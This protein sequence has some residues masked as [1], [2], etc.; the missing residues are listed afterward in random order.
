[1]VLGDYGHLEIFQLINS[2]LEFSGFF[3]TGKNNYPLTLSVSSITE[4]N[5][6]IA[7]AYKSTGSNEIFL[8]IFTWDKVTVVNTSDINLNYCYYDNRIHIDLRSN[9]LLL[10]ELLSS[11]ICIY[12]IGND[13]KQLSQKLD[14]PNAVIWAAFLSNNSIYVNLN[15]G[16][17]W[18][19][20]LNDLNMKY[21]LVS[22]LD[23]LSP[24]AKSSI[25]DSFLWSLLSFSF[26]TNEQFTNIT[27][28]RSE[29]KIENR[30]LS[31]SVW[32]VSMTTNEF[33]STRSRLLTQGS[34]H[35]PSTMI[36][37]PYLFGGHSC[38]VT[39]R[40]N[41]SLYLLLSFPNDWRIQLAQLEI[42]NG[43]IFT[44][45]HS[46]ILNENSF[47]IGSTSLYFFAKG[48]NQL[49]C[50]IRK[51]IDLVSSLWIWDG[52][53]IS[54]CDL[55]MELYI[56][57]LCDNDLVWVITSQSIRTFNKG[58][59]NLLSVISVALSSTASENFSFLSL[60]GKKY[61]QSILLLDQSSKKA[62]IINMDSYIELEWDLNLDLGLYYNFSLPV[63]WPY[64][65]K[66][67]H[68]IGL[69]PSQNH[70]ELFI[71]AQNNI[72]IV[73]YRIEWPDSYKNEYILNSSFTSPLTAISLLSPTTN[74]LI[75]WKFDI[76]T[77]TFTGC[78]IPKTS[79]FIYCY[80]S[81]PVLVSNVYNMTSDMMLLINSIDGPMVETISSKG[82]PIS[83]GDHGAYISRSPMLQVNHIM[84][85]STTTIS[86]DA[87]NIFDIL[88]WQSFF[89]SFAEFLKRLLVPLSKINLKSIPLDLLIIS[90]NHFDLN[91]YTDPNVIIETSSNYD[92][93]FDRDDTNPLLSMN[94]GS[95]DD[96]KEHDDI[97]CNTNF[98]CHTNTV[99]DNFLVWINICKRINIEVVGIDQNGKFYLSWACALCLFDEI[100][101]YPLSGE[102]L[103]IG[104]HSENVDKLLPSLIQLVG[105]KLSW[106]TYVAC[107]FPLL[108][109][110]T[111]DIWRQEAFA[112]GKHFMAMEGNDPSIPLVNLL[113]IAAQKHKLLSSLWR[114]RGGGPFGTK[115]CKLYDSYES[116]HTNDNYET[117]D[118]ID[119]CS[120]SKI[121]EVALKNAFICMS[122][123]EHA[124]A[125]TLFI[126]GNDQRAAI[127]SADRICPLL[128][129]LIS[130]CLGMYKDHHCHLRIEEP[131]ISIDNSVKKF[132]EELD[133]GDVVRP[134]YK[135][136]LLK[137]IANFYGINS[138][139]LLNRWIRPFSSSIRSQVCNYNFNCI[140]GAR[141]RKDISM[142]TY[143]NVYK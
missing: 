86:M 118:S 34:V 16:S 50:N 135:L 44:L 138:S 137:N 73:N 82:S 142:G 56:G 72:E 64:T 75:F 10:V 28:I 121:K 61:E 3:D 26:N 59:H 113:F 76:L 1:M 93:L 95:Y 92:A 136:S 104:R 101:Q 46:Q 41:S 32:N 27:I 140:I 109:S 103:E 143:F 117:K 108:C 51:S 15:N 68:R 81:L 114:T 87:W 36:A 130:G 105:N 25:R 141:S 106:D 128:G 53:W 98:G 37:F 11:S 102:L 2:Q 115:L 20:K 91:L 18:I 57:T 116:Y 5:F 45:N 77:L 132:I 62:F 79:D 22:V 29:E 96:E 13:L 80:S 71:L 14:H 4:L 66:Y 12:T 85:I 120:Y 107:K 55:D 89:S 112:L 43:Y 139:P 54:I 63:Q 124:Y 42:S 111:Q 125:A 83:C 7:V 123:H 39:S 122:K 67:N 90:S 70:M 21:F 69:V 30:S 99:P 49:L 60:P 97:D 126:I 134:L 17:T 24:G 23:P 19:W 88:G 131:I 6:K 58:S 100:K 110:R 9:Q 35:L 133:S 127:K 48:K 94:E 74:F 119:S 84:P 40:E 129:Y 65:K 47:D 33:N 8:S 38:R 52:L 31:F 78:I